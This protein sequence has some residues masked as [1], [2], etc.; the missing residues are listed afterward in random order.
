[1]TTLDVA[2]CWAL[3]AAESI[4]RVLYTYNA[5]PSIRPVSYALDDQRIVFRTSAG[6]SLARAVIDQ[7]VAFETDVINRRSHAG[8][9]VV[10]TGIAR[11]VAG[12][13]EPALAAG[14]GAVRR[15]D[16]PSEVFFA[17]TPAM[18]VGRAYRVGAR[19]TGC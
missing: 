1:M 11:S 19:S 10:A 17:I 7:V 13:G 15:I 16:G 6:S 14:R 4:G 12:P 2:T 5:L 8:W 3:L 18:L 9:S